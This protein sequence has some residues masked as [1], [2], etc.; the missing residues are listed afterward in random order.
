MA[1]RKPDS[2]SGSLILHFDSPYERRVLARAESLHR[3]TSHP[4]GLTTARILR[5]VSAATD[6]E[7]EPP[8]MPAHTDTL[9]SIGVPTYNR[10]EKLRRMLECLT[11]QTHRNLDIIVSDNASPGNGTEEVVA[12]AQRADQRIRY[13]RQPHNLGASGNFKFV[14]DQAR[15]EFFMWA[16][17]DDEVNDQ[18]V[19]SLLSALTAHPASVLAYGRL[20]ALNFET[21]ERISYP[22][23]AELDGF[24]DLSARLRAV[25]VAE[26]SE[27]KANLWHA[28]HRREV[29][30]KA[31]DEPLL[32]HWGGDNLLV[33]RLAQFG[34]FIY[35][36]GA[37]LAKGWDTKVS[38]NKPDPK[39]HHRE[40]QHYFQA[41][42]NEIQ[43]ASLSANSK[44]RLLAE[45]TL[46]ESLWYLR[47]PIINE[48]NTS[49]N[50]LITE[51]S[52]KPLLSPTPPDDASH[53][54][55][56]DGA[57]DGRKL[58]FYRQFVRP[59]EL[60][61]DIGANRGNRTEA[62]LALGARVVAVEPQTECADILAKRFSAH[63]DFHLIRKAVDSSVGQAEILICNCDTISSLSREWIEKVKESKRFEGLDW[64]RTEKVATTTLDELI[65][66]YGRP[67]FCKI[68]V[69][70]FELSVLKG[71]SHS[72]T[73]VCFEF[74][75]EYLE[76]ALACVDHLAGLG[77]AVFNFSPG[78]TFAFEHS[79]WLSPE[80]MKE[81][82]RQLS[83]RGDN[84]LFGDIYVKYPV[85]T[86]SHPVSAL[87]ETS[88]KEPKDMNQKPATTGDPVSNETDPAS[89]AGFASHHYQRHNQRRLEHLSGLNLPIA[90]KSVLEVGAGVGDHTGFFL[91]R[92]CCVASTEGR[93][94]NVALLRKRYS[95]IHTSF[96]DL[97]SPDASHLPQSL[98]QIVYCYGLLYHLN[99]PAEAI[100]F[101]AKHC[102]EMLLLETCVSF[103]SG[104][105]LHPCAEKASDATQSV[106]GTGCRPTR[107]WVFD[108]LRKH[109]PFVYMPLT[110]PWHE[111]FP[112]DW[113]RRDEKI[114]LSRA[115]FVASRSAI[116]NP[117]LSQ[118]IPMLQKRA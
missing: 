101:M 116:A 48:L 68:D 53:P 35:E 34:S 58:A 63:A 30:S 111:E 65:R 92:G 10:P 114:P 60:C 49:I 6:L 46:K 59:G 11:K 40:I 118:Q 79:P 95:W 43:T 87:S 7:T 82:L 50:K 77:P 41:Y 18:Y 15:A 52:G 107:D 99:R 98:Y 5:N 2:R 29:L 42:R 102:S 86:P 37:L 80:R 74:T 91:D 57:V 81:E 45:V 105:H 51:A 38:Y 69:E 108:Q 62:F 110:Q 103:G 66:E 94:E 104:R 76:P 32:S 13:V 14:L 16:A 20:D 3:H 117:V 24:R 1:H 71:L 115:V 90:G 56:S 17:D 73:C 47:N 112:M 100:A 55:A 113:S 4:T 44:S 19:E 67:A 36:P 25:L 54:P 88:R 33:F 31:W 64:T 75:P 12:E 28:L 26:E 85:T 21:S 89:L 70:G 8:P 72:V 83:A 22:R 84:V 96:L 61:F 9:V 106:S 93:M 39:E 109:L 23:I 27:G 97:D 78:E